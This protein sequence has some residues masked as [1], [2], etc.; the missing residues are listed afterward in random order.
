MQKPDF[1]FFNE[2]EK[3][4][5]ADVQVSALSRWAT[6]FAGHSYGVGVLRLRQGSRSAPA[7]APLRMTK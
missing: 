3:I 2:V 5:L 1:N 6:G 7:L 4:D